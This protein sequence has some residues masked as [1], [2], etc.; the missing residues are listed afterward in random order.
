MHMQSTTHLNVIGQRLPLDLVGVDGAGGR[1]AG[2]RGA[3]GQT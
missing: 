3:N 1:A 2:C